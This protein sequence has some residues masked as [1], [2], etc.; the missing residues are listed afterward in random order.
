MGRQ[1]WKNNL[2][3]GDLA[4]SPV[5]SVRREDTLKEVLQV[6]LKHK[7]RRVLLYESRSVIS[8]RGILNFLISSN[9]YEHFKEDPSELLEVTASELPSSFP[10][11]VDSGMSIIEAAR[12]MNPDYGDCLICDKGLVTFWDLVVK[13][14]IPKDASNAVLQTPT[15]SEDHDARTDASFQ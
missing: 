15:G 5:L 13:L 11:F 14:E 1:L 12:L 9:N 10:P 6:M 8:D 3:V 7:K 2:K 4:S